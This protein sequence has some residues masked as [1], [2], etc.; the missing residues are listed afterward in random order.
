MGGAMRF[1][2]PYYGVN[3]LLVASYA[4]M[5]LQYIRFGQ[6]EATKFG[7]LSSVGELQAWVS[8][9]SSC[10]ALLWDVLQR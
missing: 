6:H 4:L 2:D 3:F 10:V 8:S 9:V 7:K 5:R 1:A